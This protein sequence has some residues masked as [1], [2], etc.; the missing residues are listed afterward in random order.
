M[1]SARSGER[2]RERATQNRERKYTKIH[3]EVRLDDM[4][5]FFK[6]SSKKSL[7]E[8]LKPLPFL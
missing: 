5:F 4:D 8:F 1:T 3:H 2:E 7:F 6:I